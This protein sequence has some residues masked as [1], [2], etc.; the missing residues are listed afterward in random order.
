MPKTA[1]LLRTHILRICFQH[2]PLLLIYVGLDPVGVSATS[3]TP[4]ALNTLASHLA[5]LL[6]SAFK[7]RLG[8]VGVSATSLNTLGP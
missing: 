5:S 1:K 7:M 3:V 2:V 4:L 6:F 8:L